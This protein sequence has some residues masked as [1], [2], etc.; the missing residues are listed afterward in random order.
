MQQLLAKL[1]A[2]GPGLRSILRNGSFLMGVTLG[3]TVLRAC[4]VVVIAHFI[5]AAEYGL[6]A[7]GGASYGLLMGLVIFGFDFLIAR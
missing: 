3:E 1:P 6:W 7:Y 5:S 4:Y 2:V